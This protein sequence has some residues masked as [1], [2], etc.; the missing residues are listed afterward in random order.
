MMHLCDHLIFF[1][2]RVEW[3]GWGRVGSA[4][5]AGEGSTSTKSNDHCTSFVII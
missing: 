3:V 2:L 5:E 1:A 4:Q